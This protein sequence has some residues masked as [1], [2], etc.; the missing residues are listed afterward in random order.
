MTRTQEHKMLYGLLGLGAVATFFGHG[1]WAVRGKDTFV[2]LFTG[3]MDN[4]LGVT[5]SARSGETV[6]KAIGWFDIAVAIA[7]AALVAG[8]LLERGR[9]Y[10][11]AYSSVAIGLFAWAAVWG[12]VTAFARMTGAGEFYPEVW[13]WV[14]RA[15]NFMLPVALIY[16][17]MKHRTVH[18]PTH[19][20]SESVL[21][22][23]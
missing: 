14:E 11:L 18:I 17:V 6:V 5:V 23:V 9:L 8:A 10:R 15:P 3:S 16:I 22:E 7:L 13:D 4:V 2:T 1:M 12:F 21:T 19:M 20:T